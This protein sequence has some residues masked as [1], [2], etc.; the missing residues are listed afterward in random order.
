MR[1][2]GER[3]EWENERQVKLRGFQSMN[4]GRKFVV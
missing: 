2:M 4:L 1:T 3:E